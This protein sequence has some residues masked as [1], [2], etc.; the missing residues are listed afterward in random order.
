MAIVTPS[1]VTAPTAG[2]T[3]VCEPMSSPNTNATLLYGAWPG[4]NSALPII[5]YA[6]NESAGKSRWKYLGVLLLT[7]AWPF[8]QKR[9]WWDRWRSG[10]GGAPAWIVHR[11]TP[12][13][14]GCPA[15]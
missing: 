6:S 4:P 5:A 2:P 3:N 12:R 9:G 11:P 14:L 1:L 15:I 7:P 10:P 8:M 13:N